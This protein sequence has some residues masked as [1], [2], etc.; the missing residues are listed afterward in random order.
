MP[1][2]ASF[3]F[4]FF[5]FIHFWISDTPADKVSPLRF[6]HSR[7]LPDSNLSEQ[8]KMSF[9]PFGYGARQCLGIHLGRIEMRL[10]AAMFFRECAGARLAPSATPESM[11]VMDSFIAGVPS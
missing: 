4:S 10:A 6:D 11:D 5:K 3:I 9:N 2:T 8:A 7:W 1:A